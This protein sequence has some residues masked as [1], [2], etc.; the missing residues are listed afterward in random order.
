[1]SS[2]EE[3]W[4]EKQESMPCSRIDEKLRMPN[5]IPGGGDGRALGADDADSE[6][7]PMS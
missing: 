1:V 4:K 3:E 2:K 5:A 6:Q 7:L